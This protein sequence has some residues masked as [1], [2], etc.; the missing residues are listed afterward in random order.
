MSSHDHD[1][2]ILIVDRSRSCGWRLR[3]DLIARGAT[4]HVF[5]AFEPAL[6]LLKSKKI[7]TAMIEF[8]ADEAAFE[9]CREADAR[10]V[11]LV[12]T[13]APR[14]PSRARTSVQSFVRPDRSNDFSTVMQ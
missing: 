8:D 9:F 6:R 10:S 1:P 3:R 12:F 11:A 13:T 4:V 14:A 2:S 7:D 5:H